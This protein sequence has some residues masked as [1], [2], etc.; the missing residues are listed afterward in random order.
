MFYMVMVNLHA[1]PPLRHGAMP[2]PRPLATPSHPRQNLVSHL[3]FQINLF[4][5][6]LLF[7]CGHIFLFCLTLKFL[8]FHPTIN[9]RK[10]KESNIKTKHA[11]SSG[12]LGFSTT[13]WP[14]LQRPPPSSQ[15]ANLFNIHRLRPGLPS[16]FFIFFGLFS[17][18]CT[19]YWPTAPL[20]PWTTGL[21][22]WRSMYREFRTRRKRAPGDISHTNI[23]FNPI[24]TMLCAATPPHTSLQTTQSNRFLFDTDRENKWWTGSKIFGSRSYRS[25]PRWGS[26]SGCYTDRPANALVL[27]GNVPFNFVGQILS[28]LSLQSFLFFGQRRPRISLHPH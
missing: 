3:L 5:I 23:D 6:I 10:G 4:I 15:N 21:Y 17:S 1:L 27:Q 2:C 7:I 25:T 12:T 19:A 11:P 8:R 20:A 18:F 24:E 26:A 16:S 13:P 22:P 9:Q 14:C 28:M